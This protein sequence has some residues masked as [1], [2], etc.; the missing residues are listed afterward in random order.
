MDCYG[1]ESGI[2]GYLCRSCAESFGSTMEERLSAQIRELEAENSVLRQTI[3]DSV[4]QM[5]E[6]ANKFEV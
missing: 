4:S 2:S 1:G 5:T 6:S 3:M